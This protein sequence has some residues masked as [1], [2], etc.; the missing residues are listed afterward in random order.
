MDAQGFFIL[1]A[2]A[3]VSFALSFYGAAVGLILG[4]L[5]LPL[6]MYYLPSAIAGMATNLVI[7]GLGALSGAIRHL[8]EGRVSFSLLFLMGIPSIVGAM[9]GARLILHANA[10]WARLFVGGFLMVSGMNLVLVKISEGPGAAAI[11]KIRIVGEVFF[12][13]VIGFLSSFTGLMLGTLRLPVIIRFLKADP[14][15][16]VGTNMALGCVTAFAGAASMRH[17]GDNLFLLVIAPPTIL[18]GYLGARFTGRFKKQSLQRLV[19]ATIALTGLVMAVE[20][21]YQTLP[22][23]NSGPDLQAQLLIDHS[24][25]FIEKGKENGNE[26]MKNEPLAIK[27]ENKTNYVGAV[28]ASFTNYDPRP[29]SVVSRPSDIDFNRAIRPILS[30]NCYSCHGPDSAKRKAHLRLDRPEDALAALRSGGFAIVPGERHKS[31]L[32]LRISAADDARMPPPKTGK[33]LTAADIE[34]L[35]RWIDEGAQWQPH[36]AY[37]APKKP[38]LPQVANQAWPRNEIDRFIL[39]RLE[40]EGMQPSPEA[41][42]PTLLRR[43][44]FDLT[45]LPPTLDEV[46]E[47]VNDHSPQ[48]YEKVVERLFH[49]PHFGER[50]AQHWLDLARYADTNGYR[51]DNHRD[52][53]QFR[54][55]VIDAFNRNMPYD[56]FT[57]EQLAGDLLPDA[58][59]AQK[60]ASG[61]HR[62][63]MVNFGNGSDPK[64]YL[65][66]AVMDRVSTTATVWL[67]TTMACAQCHDHKYDPITQKDFY[68]LYAFFNNSAEKGLDGEKDNPI[69]VLLTPLPVH[70]AQIAN[71]L[72]QIADLNSIG[73]LQAAFCNLALTLKTIPSA[74][75]MEELPQPRVTHILIGGDYLNPGE[76]V[77]A[78]VPTHLAAWCED[79]PAN[80]LGLARWLTQPGHPLTARVTVNRFWQML[81][82]AGLVKTS[83][84][85]G[86]QGEPPSHPEL[87]DWLADEFAANWDVKAILKRM[88]LSATYRQSS[89]MTKERR[90]RDPHNR[91]L[92]RGPRQRLD[93]EM[94]R[95]LALASSGL[96]DHR[97][98]GP[99]VRPYQP[100]GLWEQ[101][102][103]GGNYSSQTYVQSSGAD[104]YRRGIYVYWKRSLPYPA[105]ATFDA[106][107]REACTAQR[108]RTNTPLQALVLLNDPTYIEAAR[109]LAD[110]TLNEAGPDLTERLIYAFRLCTGRKPSSQELD[111]LTR[112]YHEQISNFLQNRDAARELV[113]IGEWKTYQVRRVFSNPSF[114]AKEY[115]P[116]PLELAAWTAV[117]NLLLNLDETIS[118]E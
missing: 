28:P 42:R 47:F 104:L 54:D 112:V 63:T 5:R 83:D 6:L 23:R 32:F 60:I 103:L 2:I 36:W 34:L 16:A 78:G 93:A 58:T 68:R 31:E 33:K 20:G 45:G 90:D 108:P 76:R 105:L 89:K 73:N 56:R 46:D 4:H 53:W 9:A 75:V 21:L 88:V 30:N 82:G 94:I 15:V 95:D 12:G 22:G 17:E 86:S 41:D 84:D 3:V 59:P 13:L 39:D 62:N 101:V 37:L 19:G 26:Q 35:G 109:V 57:V 29:S 87:L 91:L 92:A 43:L 85:F 64:E 98:G 97:I 99:S 70:Q 67:G 48:A 100:S 69:P 80:R 1:A 51:L 114:L 74:M 55:W 77:S 50:M 81:F 49:S 117:G 107:N 38:V 44:S 115:L 24:S 72:V 7:S 110:R 11:R 8:R 79:F 102:A 113:S 61:F 18:G 106:S 52:M 116:H 14:R 111:I 27:F 40:R 25:F 66:K 65:A 118:K 10:A 96:L 71:C